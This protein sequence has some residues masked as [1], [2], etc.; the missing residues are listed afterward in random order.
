MHGEDEVPGDE[1]PQIEQMQSGMC[2][3]K[4]D[5]KDAEDA[6]DA[7]LSGEVQ[8]INQTLQ[9]YDVDYRE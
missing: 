1:E 6:A 2:D 3:D 5:Q 7:V 8:T 9:A 4:Q